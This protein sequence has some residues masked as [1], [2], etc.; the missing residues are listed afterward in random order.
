[1]LKLSRRIL[2]AA[3]LTGLAIAA[4]ALPA[5]AG[6]VA[7]WQFDEGSG[8]AISDS[9]GLGNNG[10]LVNAK[11]NTW[12]N[13]HTG[14]G[15][16]FDGTTGS[17]CTYVTIPDAS[18]LHIT[19]A[20]S[21]AAW[22][23]CDDTGRDAP[24][25]AKE[26][27]GNLS[28]WFGAYGGAHFGVLLDTD[29]NQPWTIMDRDQGIL[30]PGLWMQ[31]VSTWDGATLRHYLNGVQLTETAAFAE[32]IF[33]GT[34]AL[35]IGANVP[36]NS[37]AFK[38]IIDDL[39]LFNHALSPEEVSA[40]A[41]YTPRLVG[42]WSFD[43]GGGT[44]IVDSS[45]QTNHGTI[46]NLQTNTWT[47][48]M[49][50]A[51]LYFPG[52][53]GTNSTHV[54]VPDSPS[55]RIAGDISFAAWVRC[56]DIRRDAPVMAKEGDSFL[57]YWFGTYGLTTEGGGPGNF[58][59]L[60][61]ADGNQPWTMY[62]RDQGNI[63][64][65][66]WVH[67]AS[68][69]SNSVVRHYFNGQALPTTGTFTG[70]IHV[71]DAFLAIGV[72]SLYNLTARQTAFKGAIDEVRLYN[73]A[74]TAEAVRALYLDL[75]FKITSVTPEGSDL[76]VAWTCTPGSSYVVQTNAAIA[77][78]PGAFQDLSP[79]IVIPT[80]FPGPT[81]NWLHPGILSNAAPLFYRVRRL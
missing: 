12:T 52:V 62:D 3:S 43:E 33:A 64:E 75:A 74:L 72:N 42:H 21:F 67:L 66:Q 32:P 36:Y 53:T 49:Q 70:P 69:R 29:G 76:R 20:I 65:G 14:T 73:Y 77:A 57:S 37:T 54:A 68:V 13:G 48:G 59:M 35:I 24:I 50:G 38:G 7:H 18:S 51:A 27:T 34:G 11:I 2:K 16:Y 26:G 81:T 4:L 80:N 45:G 25:I 1:M 10:T 5:R 15:L 55:L 71:S 30:T 58:G 17:G 79:T 46:I 8:S 22:I 19:N 40:L 44:N 56:D 41:G 63:P 6:L 47:A 60:L 31:I 9:S 61:D 78:G 23:R 28:Y 39:R